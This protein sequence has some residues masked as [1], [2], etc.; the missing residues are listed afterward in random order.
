MILHGHMGFNQS[1]YW[2][3]RVRSDTDQ[4]SWSDLRLFHTLAIPKDYRLQVQS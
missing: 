3:T 4:G 1:Y 2:R